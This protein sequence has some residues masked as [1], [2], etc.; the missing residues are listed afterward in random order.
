M[1]N[2]TD[3][4]FEALRDVETKWLADTIAGSIANLGYPVGC[5][6]APAPEHLMTAANTLFD[7][8]AKFI[9]MAREAGRE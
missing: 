6:H 8:Y 1:S 3:A 5:G 2:V 9:R 7:R 4:D